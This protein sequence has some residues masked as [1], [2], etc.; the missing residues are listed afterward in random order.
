MTLREQIIEKARSYVGTPY[1]R[2]GR[3]PG[4]EHGLDCIGVVIALCK[5]LGIS[6]RD[7]LRYDVRRDGERLQTE[8]LEA[9]AVELPIE[10]AFP[11]DVL[12]FRRNKIWHVGVLVDTNCIVHCATSL[13]KP[14][15]GGVVE[16]EMNAKWVD[17]IHSAW[18]LPGVE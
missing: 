14:R 8:F 4:P 12:F 1:H 15:H 10:Q 16:I 11:G 9:G 5:E 2:V 13:G 3:T 18:R 6:N 7:V 17:R